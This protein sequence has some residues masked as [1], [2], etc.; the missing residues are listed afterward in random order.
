MPYFKE[1]DFATVREF[2]QQHPFVVVCG[3][4]TDLQP[5]ATHIPVLIEEREGRLYLLG[6]IMRQTDH[7][8][9]FAQNPNVLAIFSGP[10]TYVSASLYSNPR[11]A[12]TWNYMTVHARGQLH[13]LD[14]EG[15]L[16]LLGKLT[17]HFEQNA[18]SP[19]SFEKL[20]PDYVERLSKAIIAFEIEVEGIDNVFK[21]SQNRD[22]SSYDHIIDHLAKGDTDS[23][24]IATAMQQRS[25]QLFKPKDPQGAD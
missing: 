9:T 5:V 3:A 11:Q 24:N 7:H 13:F 23:R 4:S 8:K 19:A 25:S 15:L 1:K 10:H 6:H 2:M 22:E 21:L 16:S 18:D 20:P 12:S 14:D 17:S